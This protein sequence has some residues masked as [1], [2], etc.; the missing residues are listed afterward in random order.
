MENN[1]SL[2]HAAVAAALLMAAGTV[3]AAT[4]TVGS[5][6]VP[7]AGGSVPIAATFTGDGETVAYQCDITFDPAAIASVTVEGVGTGLCSNPSPGVVRLLDGTPAN[8]PMGDVTTCN[9]TFNVNAGSDGDVIALAIDPATC[10]FNNAA[11]DSTTGHTTVDGSITLIAE[12]PPTLTFD[13]TPVALPGGVFGETVD[14]SIPA[15][16]VTSTGTDTTEYSCVAPAG[17]SIAPTSGSYS[18]T[19]TA[20]DDIVVSATLGAA[21][22]SGDVVCTVTPEGGTPV[23]FTIPVSAP[24]GTEAAPALTPTPANGGEVAVGGGAP[25]S[26]GTGTIAVT[27]AGGA[28]TDVAEVTCTAAAP[29]SISPATLSFPVGSSAQSFT[30]TVPLTDA[31]Q[32]FPNAINC[33]GTDGNGA[34]EWTFDVSAPAGTAAPTFIP[35][36]SLWSKFALIGVFAALGLLMVGL[37]RNH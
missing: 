33:S 20:A 18:N 24:A 32:S 1:K 29:V 3:S 26:N 6:T 34:I 22:L 28:G 7:V 5:A 37:R 14:A 13:E 12:G 25:G 30:V 27:A 16:L 4:V 21:A 15:T 23:T 2:L 35:A 36:T 17:F 10:E 11:G 31:A 8:T 9:I 19:D